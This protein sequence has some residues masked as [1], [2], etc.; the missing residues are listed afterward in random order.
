MEY[1][2]LGK[3]IVKVSE[4]SLG[5]WENFGRI[6]DSIARDIL[7]YCY[8]NGVNSIDCADEYGGTGN[9]EQILGK[10][11]KEVKRTDV[12]ISSK[13]FWDA[14]P[15]PNDRGLSRKHIFES[16]HNSLRNMDVEYIDIYYAHRY[17]A[18]VI[19][20]VDPD[21]EEVV[22]AFDDLVHQGKILYWG[23]SAWT[24][25]QLAQG[26]GLCNQWNLYKPS[27]EQPMYNMFYR[28]GVEKDLVP[29]ARKLG[30][31]LMTYTPLCNGILTGKYNQGIPEGSRLSDPSMTWLQ[32]DTDLTPENIEKVKKLQEV[33]GDLGGTLPQ[34]A[35][36]WLLRL[37]EMSSVIIGGTKLWQV[38]DNLKAVEMRK[39]LTP[40][41]LD[42]IEEILDNNPVKVL[43][44]DVYEKPSF[45]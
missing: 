30:F 32:L 22:R 9:A 28:E 20:Q 36:A 26:Y 34:L 43:H 10:I 19:D 35:I 21:L 4:I 3:A 16:V 37:P 44:T 27:V 29:V 23:T 17:E 2:R 18:A 1:R 31:G 42:R 11:L 24:G 40:D 33:A 12:L 25:A 41:V 38:E 45:D 7:L 6:D 14:G 15:G 8:E 5:T 39:K 13:C